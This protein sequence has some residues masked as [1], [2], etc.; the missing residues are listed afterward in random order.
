MYPAKSGTKISSVWKLFI[1]SFLGTFAV[2]LLHDS[3][4][5]YK[6]KKE[7]TNAELDA[8]ASDIF[9]QKADVAQSQAPG[10]TISQMPGQMPNQV[11]SQAPGQAPSQSLSQMQPVPQIENGL[12]FIPP[13]KTGGNPFEK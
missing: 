9:T 8:F 7:Y 1:Y 5:R 11:L 2:I 12:P 13:T 3:A 4:I 10:Q 6:A